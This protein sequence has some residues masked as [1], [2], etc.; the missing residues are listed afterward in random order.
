[1]RAVAREDT[2]RA[3]QR[4]ASFGH[5]IGHHDVIA[6][7]LSQESLAAAGVSRRI[8]VNVVV[9]DVQILASTVLQQTLGDVPAP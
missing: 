8:G 4:V 2:L 9:P 6:C 3:L 1:M 5:P 7:E